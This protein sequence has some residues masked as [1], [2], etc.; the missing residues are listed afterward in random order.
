[1]LEIIS[2][3]HSPIPDQNQALDVEFPFDSPNL[4]GNRCAVYGISLEYLYLE[5]KPVFIRDESYRN[6]LLSRF[7]IPVVS[8]HG[9]L[10]LRSFEVEAGDIVEIDGGGRLG[11]LPAF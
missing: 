9:K 4:F 10:V 6:D 3:A 2:D 11:I 5:G 1:M 8:E 7:L